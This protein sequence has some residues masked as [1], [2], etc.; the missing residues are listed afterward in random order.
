MDD[1]RVGSDASSERSIS[2]SSLR[3][4]GRIVIRAFIGALKT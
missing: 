1:F 3:D 2:P 4:V